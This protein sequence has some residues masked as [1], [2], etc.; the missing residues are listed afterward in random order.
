MTAPTWTTREM[1]DVSTASSR[2][3]VAAE[4]ARAQEQAELEGLAP[5]EAIPATPQTEAELRAGLVAVYKYR[6]EGDDAR[7]VHALGG[8][9]LFV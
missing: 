5:Q 4:R 9:T 8:R 7:P 2:D 6:Q 3:A 1:I